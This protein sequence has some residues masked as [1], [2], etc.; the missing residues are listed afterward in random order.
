MQTSASAYVVVEGETAQL[1]KPASSKFYLQLSWELL[2]PGSCSLGYTLRENYSTNH[3]EE[4]KSVAAKR[5]AGESRC[6]DWR[7]PKG[8]KCKLSLALKQP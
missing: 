7:E 2:L 5:P 6:V 4:Q 1:S 8:Q 3:R